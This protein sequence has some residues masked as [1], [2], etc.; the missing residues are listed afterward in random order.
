MVVVGLKT[1]ICTKG[2]TM[3]AIKTVLIIED[4]RFIGEMYVRSMRN[5]GYEVDWVTTGREGYAA[6]SV[7][8][9][10]LILL[11]IMLPEQTGTE[12]LKSLR[13]GPNGDIIAKSRVIVLTNF[14]QDDES[15]TSMQSQADGY[16][17]KA[18]ITPRKLLDIISQMTAVK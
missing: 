1:T 14:D 3:A 15:R 8:K 12:V 9:Y 10:D 18:D 2:E 5:N 4:D 16:L 13:H 7:K 17:I 11:D 6:A